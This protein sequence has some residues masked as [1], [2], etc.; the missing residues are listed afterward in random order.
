MPAAAWLGGR[1]AAGLVGTNTERKPGLCQNALFH[2]PLLPTGLLAPILQQDAPKSY[3]REVGE[4]CALT[5]HGS[6]VAGI[7]L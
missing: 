5:T 6:P 1:V 4:H 7:L 3:P 2:D